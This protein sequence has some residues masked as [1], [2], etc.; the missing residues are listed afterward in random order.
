M[1]NSYP[2]VE[3][4]MGDSA[5]CT[6]VLLGAVSEAVVEQ[7]VEAL[8]TLPSG[9]VL[10]IDASQASRLEAAV[11]GRLV[12]AI[13]EHGGREAV[14]IRGLCLHDSRLLGYLGFEVEGGRPGLHP[15]ARTDAEPLPQAHLA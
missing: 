3:V 7:V 11:L 5:Q 9:G 2:A 8:E 6:V 1:A 13:R 15:G 10:L 12:R 14:R 4:S